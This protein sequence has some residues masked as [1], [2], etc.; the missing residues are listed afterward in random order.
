MQCMQEGPRSRPTIRRDA[1]KDQRDVDSTEQ[2]L[3]RHARRDAYL[4]ESLE[5]DFH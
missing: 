2:S 5:R 4:N 1:A 3:V